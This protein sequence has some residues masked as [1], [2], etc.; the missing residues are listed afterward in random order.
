MRSTLKRML[1]ALIAVLALSA[2]VAS[3]AQATEGP[4]YKVAGSRLAAGESKEFSGR[5]TAGE[6]IKMTFFSGSQTI[7]CSGY[8]VAPGAKLLGSTGAN[9]GGASETMEFSGCNVSVNGEGCQLE[10]GK[11]KTVPLTGTLA[12]STATRTGA[13]VE[14]LAPASGEVFATLKFNNRCT[15][16]PS[17][18]VEGAAVS[19]AWPANEVGKELAEALTG[20]SL[21]PRTPIETVWVEQG[22]L[23]KKRPSQHLTWKFSF[24]GNETLS[25]LVGGTKWGVYTH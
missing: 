24:A 10:N 6:V 20:G 15:I 1:P 13:V 17:I 22:G 18:Q 12:Y 9:A 23:L 7:E 8:K 2:A 25:E 4:F 11:F 16:G 21:W 5:P 19:E 14:D 3:A